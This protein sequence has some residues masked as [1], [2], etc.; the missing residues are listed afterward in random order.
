[1]PDAG[2]TETGFWK[3]LGS[4]LEGAPL[5]AIKLVAAVLMIGDHVDTILL[6]GHAVPLWRLGRIAF[7]LFCLAAA[8]HLARGH[9]PGRYV[10]TLLLIAVPTQP[11]YA[12][13]FP[14]GT[15]EASILVTLAAGTA[16]AVW[17]AKAGAWRHAVL[18]A[19]LACVLL[20]PSL[21]KTGVDFG[22]AGVLVPGAF[23]LALT[24]RAGG[25][26]WLVAVILALNVHGWHP[27]GEAPLPSA[28]FDA[29]TIL[30]GVAAIVLFAMGLQ[31][32]PRF[33][34][35]Y[36]LHA[37]YPGHLLALVGLRAAG[38]AIGS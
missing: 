25:V 21:A 5:D 28:M 15:T 2:S 6:D 22:L 1:M 31:G 30:V 13:A 14:Y 10:L 16:F 27:R 12:T 32:R 4:R 29:A 20:L 36:A 7:P 8:L 19:G 33:L 18:A 38:F 17:L 9:D 23:L 11:I 37:F 34:P 26:A 3:T 24:G 35:R